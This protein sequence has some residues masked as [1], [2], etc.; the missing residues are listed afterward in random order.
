M[1]IE[2]LAE[3]Q[4]T[5]GEDKETLHKKML[6]QQKKE[7]E[8]FEKKQ[9]AKRDEE[10]RKIKEKQDKEKAIEAQYQKLKKEHGGLNGTEDTGYDEKQME[11]FMKMTNSLV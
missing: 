6:E 8:A 3:A 4:P 11:A 7:K 1:E 5:S 2:K 9:K 10:L